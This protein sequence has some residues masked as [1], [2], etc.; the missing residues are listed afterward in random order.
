[1]P[2]PSRFIPRSRPLDRWRA[3]SVYGGDYKIRKLLEDHDCAYVLTVA[4]SHKVWYRYAQL[5]VEAL[6]AAIAAERWQRLSCGVGAKGERLYDWAWLSL[7]RILDNPAFRVGLLVRRSLDDQQHC[8]YYLT[9]APATT[10]LTTLVQVAGS[11]WKVEACFELAKQEVG[12]ADY[13]VRHYT[14]WY[15]HI[16]LSM[17]A[18]A[19]LA[20][21][22][23]ALTLHEHPKK[24]PGRPS[25]PRSGLATRTSAFAQPYRLGRSSSA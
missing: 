16:T 12:L 2:R 25:S 11:R 18:L 8:T 24:R 23:H 17:L 7:P 22:R 13:E 15:R 9:F 10:V 21:V 6:S 4:K 3:D 14:A 19:F 1:M 5:A 20:V